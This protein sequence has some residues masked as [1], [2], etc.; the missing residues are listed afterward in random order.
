MKC[1]CPTIY[2]TGGGGGL[3]DGDAGDVVISGSGTT[4]LLDAAQ[5][6][7]STTLTLS[8]DGTGADGA[9]VGTGANSLGAAQGILVAAAIAGVRF[10]VTE[11]VCRIT[12]AGAGYT[13]GGNIVAWIWDGAAV[14]QQTFNLSAGNTFQSVTD[15]TNIGRP[16]TTVVHGTQAAFGINQKIILKS[17]AAWTQPGSAAGTAT[18]TVYYRIMED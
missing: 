2:A 12:F 4:I 6:L 5:R 11:L 10:Y 18:I 13:G 17:S 3:S 14:N 1:C 16:S 7:Y 9:I 8:A 15:C